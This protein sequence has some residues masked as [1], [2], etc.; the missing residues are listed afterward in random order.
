M[1]IGQRPKIS[2]SWQEDFEKCM[3]PPSSSCYIH[4]RPPFPLQNILHRCVQ[5]LESLG[6]TRLEDQSVHDC[7]IIETYTIIRKVQRVAY[8][9]T[10]GTCLPFSCDGSTTRRTSVVS[11]HRGGCGGISWAVGI[12]RWRIVLCGEVLLDSGMVRCVCS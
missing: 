2:L 4:N 9:S 7:Q 3:P 10:G 8:L 11:R 6:R 5:C 1:I 12:I